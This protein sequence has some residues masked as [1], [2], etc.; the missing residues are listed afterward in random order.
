MRDIRSPL[1]QVG[2]HIFEMLCYMH[3]VQLA[4]VNYVRTPADVRQLKD[5][6]PPCCQRH[7]TGH[8]TECE[9]SQKWLATDIIEIVII[10]DACCITT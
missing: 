4:I 6:D 3:I 5:S 1:S 9:A 2:V 7:V 10:T 8:V